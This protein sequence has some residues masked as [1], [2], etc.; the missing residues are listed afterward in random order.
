MSTLCGIPASW[1]VNWMVK[2]WLAGA[3]RQLVSNA[4][5]WAVIWR[6]V[7]FG[8]QASAVPVGLAGAV[9]LGWW[10]VGSGWARVSPPEGDTATSRFVFVESNQA[11]ASVLP[12]PETAMLGVDPPSLPWIGWDWNFPPWLEA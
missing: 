1:F 8:W 11:T 5:F 12:S 3:A 10:R 9:T 6:V 2:A 4:V 7:P